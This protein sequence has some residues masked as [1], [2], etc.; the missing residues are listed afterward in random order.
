ML[1]LWSRRSKLLAN[2]V[3]SLGL[4]LGWNGGRL[5][6]DKKSRF[7]RSYPF[8]QIR[9]H[10]RSY[11]YL[12]NL[13]FVRSE[14]WSWPAVMVL[15]ACLTVGGRGGELVGGAWSW[16]VDPVSAVAL[17]D[18]L[19]IIMEECVMHPFTLAVSVCAWA[20]LSKVAWLIWGSWGRTRCG[21]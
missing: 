15:I 10:I 6:S 13:F 14:C 16:A 3:W 12:R 5:K 1:D 4:L 11:C 19:G 20:L 7:A 9:S 18:F 17:G 21:Q 8:S 2:Q